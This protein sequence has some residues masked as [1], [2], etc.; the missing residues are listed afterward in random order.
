MSLSSTLAGE[1]QTNS[2]MKVEQQYSYCTDDAD[3]VCKAT[4]GYI[5][6]ITCYP[7]DGTAEA[8][9]VEIRDSATAAAGTILW[10][11]VIA[12]VVYPPKNV[13]LDAAATAKTTRQ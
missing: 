8:G 7:E 13:I 12:A 4:A 6:T 5:H 3:L 1:D 11:E 9:S 10:R 2:V